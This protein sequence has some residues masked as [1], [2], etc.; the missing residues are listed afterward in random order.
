MGKEG[1]LS[2]VRERGEGDGEGRRSMLTYSEADGGVRGV[3]GVWGVEG[4]RERGRNP[5][6]QEAGRCEG[7][8]LEP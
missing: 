6:R 2:G 1:K 5:P 4:L 7:R 8:W 3:R